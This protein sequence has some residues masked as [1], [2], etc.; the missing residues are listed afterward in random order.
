MVA[1]FLGGASRKLERRKKPESKEIE[2]GWEG[3]ERLKNKGEE[4][5]GESEKISEIIS[6]WKN[7]AAQEL[8]CSSTRFSQRPAPPI[9]SRLALPFKRPKVMLFTLFFPA[10][11]L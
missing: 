1:R 3:G 11:R 7:V 5:L 8:R 10:H 2:R 6:P 9:T 4:N